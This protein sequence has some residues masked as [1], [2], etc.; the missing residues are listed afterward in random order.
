MKKE[1]KQERGVLLRAATNIHIQ[2]A[3]DIAWAIRH[4][5][6]RTQKNNERRKTGKRCAVEG[7]DKLPRTGCNGHCLGHL[8]QEQKDAKN[9]ERKK[10][11]KSCAVEGCDK[12]PRTG[13]NGHCLGHLTQEQKDAINDERRKKSKK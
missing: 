7:C 6:R 4:K 12:L 5:S 13:C 3:M 2:V 8:T 9:D 11:G 1:G 10:K